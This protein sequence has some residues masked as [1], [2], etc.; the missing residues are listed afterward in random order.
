MT[1]H[2]NTFWLISVAVLLSSLLV[3]PQWLNRD[4]VATFLE[5]LGSMAFAVYIVVSLLRATVMLPATPFVLAGAISFPDSLMAVFMV[6]ILGIMAGALLLYSFPSFGG[7]DIYLESKYPRQIHKIR[8]KMASPYAYW[9]IAGWSSFP[10]VPTD[11]IC[12]V[13]GL[14]K[15]SARKV[16]A[17]VLMGEIPIVAFYI[18]VGVEI[19]ECLRT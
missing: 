19:S 18:F 16:A 8:K 13:A 3:F 5:S 2:F 15:M 6:S 4:A 1:K 10:L 17:A 14:A 11:A 12:Y 9:F 7:Y